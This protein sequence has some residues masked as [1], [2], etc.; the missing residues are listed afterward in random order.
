MALKP[1]QRLLAELM[2]EEPELTNVEYAEKINIDIKTLYKWKK[3]EEF[4]EYYH[5]LCR[6]KFKNLEQLAIQRLKENVDMGYQKAIEYVLDYLGYKA[7]DKIDA[8]I[9]GSLDINVNIEE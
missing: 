5:S 9:E 6:E 3:T 2:V 1:K 8:N 4:E 7:T